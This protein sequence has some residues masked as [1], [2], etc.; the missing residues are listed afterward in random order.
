MTHRQE[1]FTIKAKSTDISMPIKPKKIDFM[2][3]M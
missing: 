2:N 1:F 3:F